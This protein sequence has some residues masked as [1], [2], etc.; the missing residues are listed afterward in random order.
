MTWPKV[1]FS[2]RAARLHRR[3]ERGLGVQ[4]RLTARFMP[5]LQRI[6]VAAAE[7]ALGRFPA[8][9]LAAAAAQPKPA[10]DPALLSH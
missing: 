7:A 10:C 8:D 6:E 9:E 2:S 3:T 5:G 1:D 4:H